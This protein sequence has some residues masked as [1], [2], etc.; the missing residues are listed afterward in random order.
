MA[1]RSR[2]PSPARSTGAPGGEGNPL[3]FLNQVEPS[4]LG[5][6]LGQENVR[7]VAAVVA[8]L[9]R[10]VAAKVLA[11]LPAALRK[12]ITAAIGAAR[13]IPREALETIAES[14]RQRIHS[15]GDRKASAPGMIQYGGPEV[16]AAILRYASPEVKRNLREHEPELFGRLRRLMF[17]F[18][19]FR[20]TPDRSLQVLFAEVETRTLALA[21]R[22]ADPEVKKRILRNMSHRRADLVEDELERLGRVRMRDIEEAQTNIL[23]QAMALQQ[24]G[25]LIL[26]EDQDVV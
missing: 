1:D 15:G 17:T 24:A 11:N 23:D 2:S 25:R 12:Q 19:D 5:E 13:Q 3:A 16:A 7:T 22:V 20:R 18:D 6:A 8:N 10:V 4:V 21:L 14:L 26:D 9:D